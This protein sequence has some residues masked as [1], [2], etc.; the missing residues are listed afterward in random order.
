MDLSSLTAADFKRILKLL[1][2]K[3]ALLAEIAEIEA[4]LSGFNLAASKPSKASKPGR[5][6]GKRGNRGKLKDSILA[7]L[8]DSGK[9][10]ITVKEIAAKV[11]RPPANIHTWV[12]NTG[13]KLKQVK[14]V[15]EAK[16]A[17][18]E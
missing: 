16:W 12:F 18:V 9:G 1:E 15:G 7:V 13:K 8:Q 17:W 11:N 14:K 3:D 6:P 10:G 4:A 2:R 5:K